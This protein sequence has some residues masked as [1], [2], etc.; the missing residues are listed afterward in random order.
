M[1][2]GRAPRNKTIRRH[3]NLALLDGRYLYE[4]RLALA[5]KKNGG[6]DPNTF[7]PPLGKAGR[8]SPFRRSKRYLAIKLPARTCNLLGCVANH[9]TPQRC[10]EAGQSVPFSA[11][12][13]DLALSQKR[14]PEP[15]SRPHLQA[16][17]PLAENDGH[18]P[19]RLR[20]IPEDRTRDKSLPL[21]GC[22]SLWR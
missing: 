1:W 15:E 5:A 12:P 11:D 6:F 22:Q 2:E 18:L 19:R 17:I 20:C 21:A 9:V 7:L 14:A 16:P 10:A 8:F 3:V 13:L 4:M